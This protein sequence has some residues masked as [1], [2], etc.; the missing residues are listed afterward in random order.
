MSDK[1]LRTLAL[2][3]I[4]CIA[5]IFFTQG[6]M[7]P[8]WP[9][10]SEVAAPAPAV[11][12]SIYLTPATL[13]V[14]ITCMDA[15]GKTICMGSGVLDGNR[16]ITAKHVLQ[17]AVCATLLI[18]GFPIQSDRF[19]LDEKYD[20]GLVYLPPG[21]GQ[22]DPMLLA[23]TSHL[24]YG[25]MLVAATG[26]GGVERVFVSQGIYGGHAE[27]ANQIRWSGEML[28]CDAHIARGSSG[29]GI[30]HDNQLVGIAVAQLDTVTLAE[31]IE[32]L[33]EALARAEEADAQA[34]SQTK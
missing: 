9:F 5:G 20:L 21:W 23:P 34:Q 1:S 25:S 7:T 19:Y 29:G 13:F 17:N 18:D 22:P 32:H 11:P 6:P 24:A 15:D 33:Q 8:Q 28:L 14:H 30:F 2:C 3:V 12:E 16:V 26:P 27:I 4:L 10:G 31:P